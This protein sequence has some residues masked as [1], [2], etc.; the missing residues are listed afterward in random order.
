MKICSIC[1]RCYEN[2]DE[3]CEQAQHP[4]PVAARPGGREIAGNYRL[5]L[6]LE[7]D[8]AVE[9]YQATQLD[10]DES[11]AVKLIR[12]DPIET[13]RADVLRANFK[14]EA[15]ALVELNH[16]NIA[17][18]YDFGEL[19]SGELFVVGELNNDQS[20]AERL[21]ETGAP[22]EVA[23]LAIARQAAQALEAAHGV[24]AIHRN[25]N[26]TNLIVA[27]GADDS[28]SVAVRKF[29][30]GG[31][32]QELIGVNP[33]DTEANRNIVKYFSPEQCSGAQPDARTDIY[34]L[35]VVLY[36]MLSGKP[37][38]DAPE[39]ES[40]IRQQINEQPE[41]LKNLHYE[42]KALLMHTLMQAL[43]K[44]PARRLSTAS[45]FAR[46]L[47]HLEQVAAKLPSSREGISPTSIPA[48]T[49]NRPDEIASTVENDRPFDRNSSQLDQTPTHEIVNAAAVTAA[50]APTTNFIPP[51]SEARFEEASPIVFVRESRDLIA[52]PIADARVSQPEP[53]L[54][55]QQNFEYEAIV[56][57]PILIKRK[58]AA[59]I[60][61]APEP[62][63]DKTASNEFSSASNAPSIEPDNRRWENAAV[64]TTPLA[65]QPSSAA[66]RANR[67]PSSANVG[68][69]ALVAA[70][71][72][73]AVLLG[74]QLLQWSSQPSVAVEN[75]SANQPPTQQESTA[76]PAPTADAAQSTTTER[77]A[78]ATG[79]LP[80]S[81]SDSTERA[82]DDRLAEKSP[83]IAAETRQTAATK[84]NPVPTTGE[85]G[86]NGRQTAP[87]TAAQAELTASLGNWVTAT[88]S[89]DVNKQM[90]FYAP[91]VNSFY[92][93]RNASQAD[94]RAEKSRVFERAGAVDIQASKPEIV[95]S[96]DG[97]TA[98]MRFRKKY[99]IRNGQQNRTGEVL[100][101]LQWV[102]SGADWKIVSERDLKVINR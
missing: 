6:L 18:I 16:P 55:Q 43:E 96:Q 66:K 98:T 57:E 28:L 48:P 37:P 11:C 60:A 26:P 54:P 78:T 71:I 3:R 62:I 52:E 8:S 95:V 22:S 31:I 79:E 76:Q 73:G 40:I 23:A 89:R 21:R 82:N 99:S 7:R 50:A 19:A 35:G 44:N 59:A 63:F 49:T 46:Q 81:A 42:I 101:E 70:A 69:I 27:R 97:R 30:F 33:P 93:T 10:S 2:A 75:S 94:V 102:K 85:N 91:T 74:Y 15:Q 45:N 29:D 61:P 47:R 14:R 53:L 100:Q 34:S 67:L 58:E 72:L 17:R 9:T 87:S 84:E 92:R 1:G 38:F 83:P 24:G 4:A 13:A 39:I 51:P 12:L 56:S 90:N 64:V 88:N 5:D 77:P 20:L 68:L 32:R 86:A 36:E 25:I 41:S 65:T 80:A